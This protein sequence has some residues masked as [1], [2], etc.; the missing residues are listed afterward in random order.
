M[1]NAGF[2]SNSFVLCMNNY[3]MMEDF[4]PTAVAEKIKKLRLAILK[5]DECK[6]V[7]CAKKKM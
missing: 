5:G 7:R 2:E 4:A 3:R 1:F 6:K